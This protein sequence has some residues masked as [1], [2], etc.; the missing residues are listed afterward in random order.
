MQ[1][2]EA[3]EITRLSELPENESKSVL[4]DYKKSETNVVFKIS[5]P[6]EGFDFNT[7]LSDD[8]IE[9]QNSAMAKHGRGIGMAKACFSALDYQGNGNTVIA[10]FEL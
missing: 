7:Y 5:D 9:K 6:G 8:F 3:D 10:V 4:V 1:N 2:P